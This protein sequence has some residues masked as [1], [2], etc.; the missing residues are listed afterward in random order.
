MHA[1]HHSWRVTYSGVQQVDSAIVLQLGL[2]Q[3]SISE[4]PG[5]PQCNGHIAVIVQRLC[6]LSSN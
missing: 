4:P 6:D 5:V 3:S 2:G 1:I